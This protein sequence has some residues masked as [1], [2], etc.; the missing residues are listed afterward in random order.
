MHMVALGLAVKGPSGGPP[1]A[2]TAW[3]TLLSSCRGLVS[4]K[5]CCLDLSRC[6]TTES[7][8]YYACSLM[9]GHGQSH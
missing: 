9:N 6:M 7:A 3:R 5:K 8:D 4:G 2:L 1:L